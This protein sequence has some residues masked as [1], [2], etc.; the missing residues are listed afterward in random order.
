MKPPFPAAYALIAL[1]FALA[2]TPLPA[3]AQAD[4]D[5]H[6]HADEQGHDDHAGHDH[7]EEESHDDDHSGHDHEEEAGLTVEPNTMQEFG[8]VVRPVGP[9]TIAQTTRL[10]GEVV[11]NADRLAH[12]TP[13]VAGVVRE[14]KF[15]VGD[16]VKAGDV[17]AVLGSRELATARSEYLAA[18]ARL[19]LARETLSRDEKLLSDRIGTERQVLEARQA[20]RESE[21]ALNLAEQ[22]LHALGQTD[23]ELETL[24]TADDTA[25]DRYELRAPLDGIVIARELTRGEVVAEQPDE[26]PFVVADLSSVWVN[27]TVHQRDLAAV[28]AGQEAR[29]VFGHDLPHATGKIVFVSPAVDEQT[30]TANA[31]VVLDNPDGTWRPGLFVTGHVATSTSEAG[32]VVPASA[33]QDLDGQAAV[34]VEHNG[35]FEPRPVR[36][37]HRSTEA[38]EVVSGLE[39]GERVVVRNGFA[40]KAEMNR[41]ALE[42]AGHAH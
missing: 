27:L 17:M 40:L 31:R 25:L 7:G 41:G 8:I 30:R 2:T 42:H 22:S 34:F 5:G 15:S 13:S 33:I 19:G 37:G 28:R 21:I 38:V 9:G 16:R 24:A 32:V 35:T 18:Q 10:P 6:N 3:I 23:A 39:P 20:V 11:F 26:V 36:L 1:L 29:I 4:H 12:V 14:V